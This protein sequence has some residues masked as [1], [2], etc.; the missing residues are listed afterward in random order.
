MMLPKIS[1][2]IE[3][4]KF[5][6]EY[7]VY[8]SNMGNFKDAN[9]RN[10][11]KKI[12]NGYHAV[13]TSVGYRPCHRLVARTWLPTPDMENLTVDHKDSNRRNNAVYNLEWVSEDENHLRARQNELK[14]TDIAT[15]TLKHY[16]PVKN[17]TKSEPDIKVEPVASMV[18]VMTINNISDYNEK[19]TCYNEM[20][21]CGYTFIKGGITFTFK[22]MN[23]AVHFTRTILGADG[24]AKAIAGMINDASAQNKKY[25]GGKWG[26]IANE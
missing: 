19:V 23:E 25:Y 8:V 14:K 13:Y 24:K 16:E 1:L 6:S 7:Q 3:K 20:N 21:H 2:N 18:Q 9:K 5:N 22:N 15:S 17:L 12:W 10:L 11:P 26:R 4:W